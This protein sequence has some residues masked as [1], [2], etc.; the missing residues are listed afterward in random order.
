MTD[1]T[2][3]PEQAQQRDTSHTE[4]EPAPS[5]ASTG[6]RQAFQDLKRRLTNEDLANP[7][8]QKLLLEMLSNAEDERDEYKLY[9]AQYHAAD[10]DVGI[11]TEKLKG[12][13]VNEVMFAVG[14]GVGCAAIG[15]STYFWDAKTANGQICLIVGGVLVVGFAVARIMHV[16]KK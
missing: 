4:P 1:T 5:V 10:K 3:A 14:I 11:L 15:L 7:G 13:R 6:R 12:D 2:L 8:A 9:I 16:L